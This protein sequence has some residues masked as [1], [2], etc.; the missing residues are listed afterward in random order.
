MHKNYCQC[1][2]CMQYALRM[3][4][5]LQS[6]YMTENASAI[7]N[8]QLNANESYS[9]YNLTLKSLFHKHDYFVLTGALSNF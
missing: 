9:L 8:C 2:K 7:A 1:A 6:A 3:H 4:W 5:Y